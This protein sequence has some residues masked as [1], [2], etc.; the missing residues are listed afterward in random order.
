MNCNIVDDFAHG[1]IVVISERNLSWCV[2]VKWMLRHLM[3][4]N[5]HFRFN[6]KQIGLYICNWYYLLNDFYVQRTCVYYTWYVICHGDLPWAM[7]SDV[8]YFLA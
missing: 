3:Y 4:F 7:S 2:Y 5:I 8:Q 6:M 1:N